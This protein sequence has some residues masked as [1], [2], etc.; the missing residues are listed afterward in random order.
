MTGILVLLHKTL[1][2]AYLGSMIISY[3]QYSADTTAFN[4]ISTSA[5]VAPTAS[6][7]TIRP[8]KQN[9]P[10]KPSILGPLLSGFSAGVS[11]Y[12]G[13]KD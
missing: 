12:G 7:K 9:P 10:S 13:L 6:F 8:I 11:V 4:N 3:E 1:C 5:A 2:L